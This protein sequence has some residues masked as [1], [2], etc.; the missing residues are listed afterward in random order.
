MCGLRLLGNTMRSTKRYEFLNHLNALE[1]KIGQIDFRETMPALG[2][3]TMYSNNSDA[4]ASTVG[5]LGVG[6]PGELRG[7]EALHK[8]HGKLPWASLFQPAIDLAENGYVVPKDLGDALSECMYTL[9]ASRILSLW[10]SSIIPLPPHR[11]ALG[12]D[13]RAERDP[14]CARRCYLPE[15]LRT[16]PLAH[17]PS[18]RGLLLLWGSGTEYQCC[19]CCSRRHPYAL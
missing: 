7:W 18:R 4:T 16:H 9:F 1:L 13:L 14:R 2:N 3:E 11:P 15:T 12:R 5:G 6:V 19:S 10:R 8:R 17:R